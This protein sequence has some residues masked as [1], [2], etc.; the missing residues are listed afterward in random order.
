MKN[1]KEYERLIADFS[2]GRTNLLIG[3]QMVSKG[4]DFDKVGRFPC[5]DGT[6]GHS[7]RGGACAP[8]YG[9][10]SFLLPGKF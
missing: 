4:L 3:T 7:A 9:E 1:L 6:G 10:R 2:E 8:Q 5:S